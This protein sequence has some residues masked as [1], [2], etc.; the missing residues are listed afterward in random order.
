M[1]G[2]HPSTC[3]WGADHR[4]GADGPLCGGQ[5]GSCLRKSH[6][7]AVGGLRLYRCVI[8]EGRPMV[9]CFQSSLS[10]RFAANRHFSNALMVISKGLTYSISKAFPA[11][12]TLLRKALSAR[13]TFLKAD[14]TLVGFTFVYTNSFCLN[15][16]A[17]CGFVSVLSAIMAVLRGELTS[18]Q[19]NRRPAKTIALP[20]QIRSNLIIP[21]Q[22]FLPQ[23]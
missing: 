14:C 2:P 17:F 12:E 7:G 1:L 19:T 11:G 4:G 16:L 15:F 8:R 5:G 21:Y 13:I 18:N 22:D 23:S 10:L 6:P 9:S 20:L 3:C